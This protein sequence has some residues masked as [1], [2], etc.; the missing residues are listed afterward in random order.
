MTKLIEEIKQD[1][2]DL[3][4]S[5]FHFC[6]FEI[7]EQ[8]GETK[9]DK[10]KYFEDWLDKYYDCTCGEF[11][12]IIDKLEKIEI[13][14]L[15]YNSKDWKKEKKREVADFFGGGVNDKV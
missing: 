15:N 3:R 9:K 10:I 4:D 2:R 11:D 12:S 8:I 14:E 1:I 5:H 7:S 13:K 6:P